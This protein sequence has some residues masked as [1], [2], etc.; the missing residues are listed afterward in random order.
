MKKISA[1]GLAFMMIT[2]MMITSCDKKED[3]TVDP[4]VGT[5]EITETIEGFSMVIT[6][7]FN[8]DKTGFSKSE[9]GYEGEME[10]ESESFTYSTNGNK[11]TVTVDGDASVV[12]YS[13]IGNELTV[14]DEEEVLVFTKK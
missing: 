14:I 2:V 8:A 13:I 4:I 6:I 9:Y 12:T 7:T 11:L 10:T 1:L 5:W 3:E